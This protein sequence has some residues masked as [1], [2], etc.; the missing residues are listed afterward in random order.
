MT[1]RNWIVLLSFSLVLSFMVC[2]QWQLRNNSTKIQSMSEEID[3]YANENAKLAGHAELQEKLWST[4]IDNLNHQMTELSNLRNT[5]YEILSRIQ[6]LED[7]DYVVK[8][9][10]DISIPTVLHGVRIH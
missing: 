1:I 7:K 6:H 10:F 2:Q 8:E 3:Y 4:E 5:E 9:F